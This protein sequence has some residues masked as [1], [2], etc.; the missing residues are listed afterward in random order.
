MRSHVT[1]PYSRA[2]KTE[3]GFQYRKRYEVTCDDKVVE[4][5]MEARAFQY[6]KRYEVTCDMNVYDTKKEASTG[7][8]TASGMR[9]H[10]TPRPLG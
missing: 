7:F 9:S 4:L 8:N 10:V 5:F 3:V 6:R 2:K 1:G